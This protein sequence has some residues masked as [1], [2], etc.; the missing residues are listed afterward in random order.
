MYTAPR[1]GAVQVRADAF[2]TSAYAKAVNH[3]GSENSEVNKKALLDATATKILGA[4][5]EVHRALGP[6]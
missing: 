4:A 2:L 3:G 6:G 5:I 1:A